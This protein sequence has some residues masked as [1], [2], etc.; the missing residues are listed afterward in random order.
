L[1]ALQ[2]TLMHQLQ[3]SQKSLVAPKEEPEELT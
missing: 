2:E 1:Q 3:E